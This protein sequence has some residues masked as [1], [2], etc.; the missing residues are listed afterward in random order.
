MLATLHYKWIWGAL[1]MYIITVSESLCCSTTFKY[2]SH[3]ISFKD[4]VNMINNLRMTA[5]RLEM[6]IQCYH[7]ELRTRTVHRN[8]DTHFETYMERV[9]THHAS[10]PFLFYEWIDMS[11]DA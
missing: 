3:V 10:A 5:P 8:G 9:N 4:V 1:I 2:L 7:E 11:P 6:R